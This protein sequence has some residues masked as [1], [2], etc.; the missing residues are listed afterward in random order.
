M[1]SF[2]A[3]VHGAND[4]FEVLGQV[5][6]VVLVQRGSEVKVT[7]TSAPIHIKVPLPVWG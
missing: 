7:N 4:T 1:T 2:A 3:N 5:Q 6:S